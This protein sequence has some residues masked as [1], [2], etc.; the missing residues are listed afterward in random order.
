V[1]RYIP[2]EDYL[3]SAEPLQN[4]P[5]NWAAGP[6]AVRDES[7]MTWRENLSAWWRYWGEGL[8]E[9]RDMNF[10]DTIHPG[11]IKSLGNWMKKVHYD[12]KPRNVLKGIEDLKKQAAWLRQASTSV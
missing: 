8:S 10:L 5:A 12:R 6:N 9:P 4:A 2:L 7:T 3:L 1:H 11:R